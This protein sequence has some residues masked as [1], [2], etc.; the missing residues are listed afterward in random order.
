[1]NAEKRSELLMISIKNKIKKIAEQ[2]T[3]MTWSHG[4]KTGK[5]DLIMNVW[6]KM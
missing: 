5:N 2:N 3:H 4:N 6:A 1:M